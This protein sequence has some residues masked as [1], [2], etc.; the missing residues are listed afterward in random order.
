MPS[1]VEE[2]A[3]PKY[4]YKVHVSKSYAMMPHMDKLKKQGR[5]N[6]DSKGLDQFGMFSLNVG[7]ESI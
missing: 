3:N 4:S 6:S 1:T 5:L 7:S 2:L